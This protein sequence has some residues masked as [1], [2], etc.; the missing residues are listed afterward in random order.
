M[1]KNKVRKFRHSDD[2]E[3][4]FDSGNGITE[5]EDDERAPPLP[6][7]QKDIREQH[8]RRIAGEFWSDIVWE[9]PLDPKE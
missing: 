6:K 2:D 1:A 3:E 5:L 8:M 7:T 4:Q 9:E